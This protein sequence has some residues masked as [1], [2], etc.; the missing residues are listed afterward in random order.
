MNKYGKEKA[1]KVFEA[2]RDSIGVD[3]QA[4]IKKMFDK[5][6]YLG[7]SQVGKE[8]A[9]KFWLPIQHADNNIDFQQEMLK[10]LAKEIKKNNAEK[11]HYALLE[12]RIAINLKKK[13][14]FGTQVIYNLDGQAIPK[15]G[16][17]DNANVDQ[18][19]LEYDLPTF[20]NITIG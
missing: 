9:T 4:R 7:F 13:Q 8:N 18:L 15:N 10:K 12:D 1:W 5:Y 16:L 14:R 3:N 19:R 2:K 17:V 6:G 20:K 11:S